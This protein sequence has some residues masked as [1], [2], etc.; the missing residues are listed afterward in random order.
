VKASTE[1]VGEDGI[2]AFYVEKWQGFTRS[3]LTLHNMFNYLNR[4]WIKRKLDEQNTGVYDINT[5]C[6]LGIHQTNLMTTGSY[7]SSAGVIFYLDRFIQRFLHL[8]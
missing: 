4:M 7:V 3:C 1:D 8:F 6:F 5:V 2:L